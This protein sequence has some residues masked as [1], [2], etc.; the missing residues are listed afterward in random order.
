MQQRI[1]SQHDLILTMAMKDLKV[2]DRIPIELDTTE[3][4]Q[5]L[6]SRTRKI[7]EELIPLM[8]EAQSILEPKAVYSVLPV[9]ELCDDQVR[10]SDGRALRSIV[11]A[12]MLDAGQEIVPYVITV[13]PRLEERAHADK[14]L[15]RT[16]LLE[17]IA[18]HA[19][20]KAC[21]YLKSYTAKKLGHIISEFSPGSGTGELF[22]IEQQ[23]VLF[24]ILEPTKNVG[25]QLTS[26]YMMVPRKS[27]SGIFAATRE[28]YVSCAH[29]PRQCGSR[30]RPYKGKYQRSR[31]VK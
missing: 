9:V 14:N 24:N 10:L 3:V 27:V 17:K 29:C 6:E 4:L 25:V 1:D 22:A 23:Q 5:T 15:L 12:D 7:S 11:L 13:G 18:D 19:L 20:G 26:S 2:L 28:E 21:E 16:Y 31:I 30:K 8:G